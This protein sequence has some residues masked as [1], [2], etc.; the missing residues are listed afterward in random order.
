MVVVMYSRAHRESGQIEICLSLTLKPRTFWFLFT[1]NTVSLAF[2]GSVTPRAA[3][4]LSQE[5]GV[6]PVPWMPGVSLAV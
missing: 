1:S 6:Y 3:N 2:H 5:L 4:S